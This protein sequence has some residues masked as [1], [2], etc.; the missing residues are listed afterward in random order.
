MGCML[1]SATVYAEKTLT[2]AEVKSLFIGKTCDGYNEIKGKSYRIYTIDDST[3]MHA[4]A[5]RTKEFA[6]Y[7]KDDGQHC[8]EFKRA[9]RCGQIVDMGDGVYHK[10]RDGEHINTLKNLV[11]GNQLEN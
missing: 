11:E 6:W 9:T 3:L 2:A 7:V 5:K 1:L 10:L 8:V 4:N